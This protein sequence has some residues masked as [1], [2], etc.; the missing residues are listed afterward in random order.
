MSG[1]CLD[2]LAAFEAD[3]ED[4]EHGCDDEPSILTYGDLEDDRHGTGPAP[5]YSDDPEVPQ[6]QVLYP[7]PRQE[8]RP[9]RKRGSGKASPVAVNPATGE[10]G[11]IMPIG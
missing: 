2:T 9:P 11:R 8:Q 1:R 7:A 4:R 6:T 10:P 3:G 5:D